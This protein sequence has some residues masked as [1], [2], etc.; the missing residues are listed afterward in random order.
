MRMVE[1][2][3]MTL[4]AP[5]PPAQ[6]NCCIRGQTHQYLCYSQVMRRRQELARQTA[7]EQRR[8]AEEAKHRKEVLTPIEMICWTG[9]APWRGASFIRNCPS[10]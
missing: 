6:V 9:L 4:S 10:P 8:Q 2:D 3:L 7:E 5:P 1:V